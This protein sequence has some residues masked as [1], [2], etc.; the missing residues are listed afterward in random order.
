MTLEAIPDVRPLCSMWALQPERRYI[1]PW[2]FLTYGVT[3]VNGYRFLNNLIGHLVLGYSLEISHSSWLVVLIYF[4]G[5]VT[6]GVGSKATSKED[7]L[8][9]L[10]GAS[11]IK[12]QQ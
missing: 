6:G 8:S 3:H 7:E 9:P 10:L 11:G 1:E 2:K 5:V 4:L 12:D